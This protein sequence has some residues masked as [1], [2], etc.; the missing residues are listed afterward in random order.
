VVRPL[1]PMDRL[2][3]V[4]GHRAVAVGSPDPVAG[5]LDLE[6]D[7]PGLVV[8]SLDPVE[9]IAVVGEDD[10]LQGCPDHRTSPMPHARQVHREMSLWVVLLSH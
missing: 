3:L 9:G 5:S 1:V 8:G 7:I 2:E 10:H 6:G 4:P